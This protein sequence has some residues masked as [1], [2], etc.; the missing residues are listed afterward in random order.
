LA[1]SCWVQVVYKNNFKILDEA[2]TERLS[3][4]QNNS[5]ILKIIKL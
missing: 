2:K 5:G 1:S 3:V 4:C